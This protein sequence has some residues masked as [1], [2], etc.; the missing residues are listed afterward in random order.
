MK[1]LALLGLFLLILSACQAAA[2]TAQPPAATATQLPSAS[3]TPAATDTLP[4]AA[5][6]TPAPTPS[7][8]PTAATSPEPSATAT[9]ASPPM[10]VQPQVV[11]DCI[12]LPGLLGCNGPTLPLSG[13]LALNDPANQRL[14]VANFKTGTAWQVS[15]ADL[16]TTNPSGSPSGLSFSP[17]GELLAV[18]PPGNS[19]VPFNILET[20]SGQGEQ[21]VTAPGLPDWTPQDTLDMAPFRTAWS[22]AGDRA[23]IDFQ[24]AEL[25]VRFAAQPDQD[26]IWPVEPVPS[27][28][29]HQV[30]AWVPGTNLVLAEYHFASNSMWV[31]GGELYTVDVKS[32]AIKD[33]KAHMKLDFP[34]QWNPAETG[35]MV[36]GESSDS[37]TMGGQRLALLN[38]LT[39]SLQILVQDNNVL[40]STQTWLPDGKTILFGGRIPGGAP[41]G[42]PFATSGVYAIGS[43]GKGL[44][45]LTYTSHGQHDEKPQV[46]PDGKNFL[47]FR[48]DEAQMTAVLR[49]ASLDGKLDQP[50]TGPLTVPVCTFNTCSWDGVAVYRP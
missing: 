28:K 48:L 1:K 24:K 7:A 26:V 36:L 47:Y 2:T 45:A 46:L 8:A 30:I 40:I 31:T 11:K 12:L 20:A 5:S 9:L 37:P 35:V 39:G 18:Y 21:Q 13:L 22:A 34:F 41:A 42:N 33:L 3:D 43:D 10:N 50:V 23:W 6:A 19:G 17:T 29:I 15:L 16:F 38:V 27:D 44:R 14:V 4:P 49:V 25:H 32:G